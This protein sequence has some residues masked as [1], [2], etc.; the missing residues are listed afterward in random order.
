V[1]ILSDA[2]ILEE[3][4]A[5]GISRLYRELFPRLC[6][7]DST[8]E[9]QCFTSGAL[10]QPVPQHARI[11]ERTLHCPS[12][13][14]L[15][16]SLSARLS[17]PARKLCLGIAA[18]GQKDSIWHSTYYT[19]PAGWRGP[20][21]AIVYD[22]IYELFPDMFVG[23]GEDEIRRRKRTCLQ[24]ASHVVCISEHTREDVISYF[25]VPRSTTSVM[26]CASSLAL[27]AEEAPHTTDG[28]IGATDSRSYVLFVGPRWRYK[29]FD[30]LLQ[31]YASWQYRDEVVLVCAG[32]SRSWT[33]D[34]R[35]TLGRLKLLDR[36]RSLGWVTDDQLERIYRGARFHICPSLYEGFGI[37]VLEALK[38]GTLA[39]VSRASSLPEAGG[40]AAFYFDPNDPASIQQ[41]MTFA[42]E[43]DDTQRQARITAG[44][45][46]AA[47][48]SWEKS[49]Q[50]LLRILHEVG[51]R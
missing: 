32:G 39:V 3:Q 7:I 37:T 33:E 4:T 30:R 48:F 12:F 42:H 6:E 18:A 45:V 40:Q 47:K 38:C 51:D 1:R 24:R 41:A 49:A 15:P 29:N 27:G 13:R 44:R 22:L 5:G 31:A 23:R 26:Y 35:A 43:L 21:V 17:W 50:Q 16:G 19:Y 8:L 25:G 20:S 14:L 11:S 36:V 28:F 2:I 10:R 34:E 9:V 46:W